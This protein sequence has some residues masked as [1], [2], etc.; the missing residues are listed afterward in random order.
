MTT[1]V[2]K[3]SYD[4][5]QIIGQGRYGT[6]VFKGFYDEDGDDDK[7]QQPVAVKR[8]QKI[9]VNDNTSTAKHEVEMMQKAANHP[10]VLRYIFFEMDANFL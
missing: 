7:K 9:Y 3:L 4:Q 1:P 8:I 5:G 6:T 2:D 10:N